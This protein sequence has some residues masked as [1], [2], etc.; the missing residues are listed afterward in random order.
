MAHMSFEISLAALLPALLLCLYIYHKDRVEKE[1]ASLLAILFGVGAAVYIPAYFGERFFSELFDKLFADKITFSLSGIATFADT[2]SM[3]A[4]H[5]LCA[6][7]GIALIEEG[8]KFLLL[9]LIT[10]KNKNFG[11]LFDGIVYSTFV[12]LGFAAAENIAYAWINGW[13]TLLLR[14]VTTVPAHLFFGII[15][16]FFYTLWHIRSIASKKEKELLAE[17][18]ITSLLLKSPVP[19]L[20]GGFLVPIAVHGFYSFVS[21]IPTPA[22]KIIFYTFLAALYICCF[23]AAYRLS[24]ADE[25]N[26]TTADRLIFKK[27]PELRNG[28]NKE[29]E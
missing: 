6:F 19:F 5:A 3:L 23:A 20:L 8:L 29:A 12:S 14:S 9:F 10:R 2:P 1:P 24:K 26:D 27:H 28:G 4:H 7:L 22:S 16:G 18:K 11:C 15:M 25:Q 17:G 21:M 13:D